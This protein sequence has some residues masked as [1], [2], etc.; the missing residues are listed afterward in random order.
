M[1][2]PAPLP[3][4]QREPRPSIFRSSPT[5]FFTTAPRLNRGA[6]FSYL[7]V[8]LDCRA[9]L[10]LTSITA[11]VSLRRAPSRGSAPAGPGPHS[12]RSTSRSRRRSRGYPMGR[13]RHSVPA[14]VPL[15]LALMC[16][17]CGGASSSVLP[18]PPPPPPAAD[19]SL[20][21]S[22]NSISI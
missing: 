13:L 16:A 2:L 10:N 3:R 22:S 21:L 17:S 5:R 1:H 4:P 14:V 6:A 8:S 9:F 20:H 7:A 11:S 19:F 18:P 15:S 12:S